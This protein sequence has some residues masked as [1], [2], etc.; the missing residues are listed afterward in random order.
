[1]VRNV[2]REEL[3]E[4]SLPLTFLYL[5]HAWKGISAKQDKKFFLAFIYYLR[6]CNYHQCSTRYHI[7]KKC[8][9]YDMISDSH[10]VRHKLLFY[11]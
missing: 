1:M 6:H 3:L 5:S 10:Q 9:M 8:T 11:L 2:T 7:P 4:N